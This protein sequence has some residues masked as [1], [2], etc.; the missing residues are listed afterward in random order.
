[1][2]EAVLVNGVPV[3]PAA[4]AVPALDPGLLGVGVYES[5]R[6][7]DG[8]PFALEAHLAR[9]AEGAAALDIG[10]PRDA[11]RAE[12]L[13]AVDRLGAP[14]ETRIRIV[15]TAGDTRVVSADALPDRSGERADGLT[16]VTLPWPRRPDGPTA[17][18]KAASTAASRVG[19]AH[20]RAA[21][22]VTGLWVTP[23]GHV[24]EALAANV[25]AVLDGVL[26]TPP[27]ADGALAGVTRAELLRWAAEDGVE[28]AE[29]SLPLTALAR[30]PEAF[31]S[32]TSEPVVPLVA[33][34]GEPVGD[35][36]PGPVTRRLQGL[37]DR[38]AREAV[39]AGQPPNAAG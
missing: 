16:A 22:A 19:L 26:V 24:S 14:G 20:A 11:L 4:P 25:F 36:A 6:T 33:L 10:C 9:L 32:A 39:R 38:R 28:V 35:G 37:Y 12:V 3:D 23:E 2:P 7:Y 30:A 31:V 17:G 34:D 13:E 29:R 1:M 15:L 5:I 8:V 27:L 18:V 21:G